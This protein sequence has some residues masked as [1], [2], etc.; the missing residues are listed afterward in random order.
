MCN[1]L[2]RYTL[3]VTADREEINGVRTRRGRCNP[4]ARQSPTTSRPVPLSDVERRFYP[5]TKKKAPL[6]S[7]TPLAPQRRKIRKTDLVPT[8][9]HK[10]FQPPLSHIL[11]PLL[12]PKQVGINRST[13]KEQDVICIP[14]N[15]SALPS[16][17]SL[18]AAQ[19]T[20]CADSLPFL[21][22][23]TEGYYPRSWSNHNQGWM[24]LMRA[25]IRSDGARKG[26]DQFSFLEADGDSIA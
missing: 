22:Q 19:L 12:F 4:L 5:P 8:R 25:R 21:H 7:S 3:L 20:S 2:V 9:R 23:R 17:P 15:Q 13:A 11:L 6:V 1:W 24:I 18:V 10:E 16:F 14:F 26:E